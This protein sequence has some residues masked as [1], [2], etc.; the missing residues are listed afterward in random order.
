MEFFD[1]N[2]T[3]DL[4]LL[5]HAIHSPFCRRILE[6]RKLESTHKYNFA[7]GKM[8]IDNQTKLESEK[9][10]VYAKKPRLKMAFKNS[11]SGKV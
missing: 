3:K 10:Q 5:L 11:I 2:L 9:T 7:E 6:T 4:S 8:K 1:V